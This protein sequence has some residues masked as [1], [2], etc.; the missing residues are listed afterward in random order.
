MSGYPTAWNVTSNY[1][2]DKKFY[3]IW[4]QTR[5]LEPGE[6]MHSGVRQTRPE[7]FRTQEEAQSAVDELNGGA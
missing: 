1:I 5:P 6:P 7:C 2:C 4:R 3:Q